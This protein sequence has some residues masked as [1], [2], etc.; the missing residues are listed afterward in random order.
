[1][2]WIFDFLFR[3]S[4]GR[5]IVM[6]LSGLFLVL[7]LAVHLAGNLQILKS[8][9]GEAF[10]VYTKFMTSNPVIKLISYSLY[11]T[12]LL[13]TIQGILIARLNRKAKGSG[14]AINSNTNLSFFGKYMIHLGIII[15]IFLIIHL[16]QFWFK[17]KM[18]VIPEVFYEGSSEPYMDLYLI[19]VEAFKN[20][21]YVIFYVLSMVLIGFHLWHG[22]QS[23]FQSLGLNHKKYNP[24]IKGIGMIYSIAVAIGFAIIPIYIYFTHSV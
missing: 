1:M 13:H 18:G 19:V 4:V 22:F 2:K 3:S 14:Y 23:A 11:F 12:I 17:M 9:N 6:S 16:Y 21:G 10:N 20:S 7:F 15:F 8:D 5:K 24:I